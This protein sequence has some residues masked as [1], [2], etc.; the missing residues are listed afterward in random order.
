MNNVQA[1]VQAMSE[2][3]TYLGFWKDFL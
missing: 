1:N 2:T 3:S